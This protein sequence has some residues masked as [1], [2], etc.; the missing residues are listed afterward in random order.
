MCVKYIIYWR[1]YQQKRIKNINWV[2]ALVIIKINKTGNELSYLSY[3][4][5][6]NKSIDFKYFYQFYQF[7][8]LLFSILL[9]ILKN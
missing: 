1:K 7:Y 9:H 5:F 3:P 2:L 6:F 8:C 4:M